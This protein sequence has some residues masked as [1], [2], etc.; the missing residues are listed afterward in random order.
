[1]SS[2]N[3]CQV[4]EIAGDKGDDEKRTLI[5]ANVCRLIITVDTFANDILNVGLSLP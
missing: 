1:M 4:N 2:G 5:S 3:T